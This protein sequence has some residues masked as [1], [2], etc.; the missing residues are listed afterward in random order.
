MKV[1]N[2]SIIKGLSV[3]EAIQASIMEMFNARASTAFLDCL[4]V[5]G[6]VGTCVQ[7]IDNNITAPYTSVSYFIA[8]ALGQGFMRVEYCSE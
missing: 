6:Y 4:E 7:Q 8:T 5:D 1:S 2:V 3:T